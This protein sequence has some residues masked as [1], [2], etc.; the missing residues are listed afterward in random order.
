M[1]ILPPVL[2]F[3][4]GQEGMYE[5]GAREG[6]TQEASVVLPY[7]QARVGRAPKENEKGFSDRP[8]Y[9]PTTLQDLNSAVHEHPRID[10]AAAQ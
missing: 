2:S 8:P 6:F 4:L 7:K 1:P 9:M 5:I 10:I 3:H